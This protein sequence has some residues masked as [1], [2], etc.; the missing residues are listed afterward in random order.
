MIKVIETPNLPKGSVQHII[1]GEKYRNLLEKPLIEHNLA[2]IWLKSNPYVDDRLSGHADL[3]A[4]QI[5]KSM[6]LS[7]YLKYCEQID[8]IAKVEYVPD[9]IKPEYP[10]D[11]GLNFCIVGDKLFYNP[12]TANSELIEK[13]GCTKLMSVKQGY[14]KCSICV[15]DENAIITSDKMIAAATQ[16]IGMDVLYIEKPF[17]ALEG[18]EYGFIGGAAFKISVHE[19]AFTGIIENKI[20]KK[21]IE[22]FLNER[23]IKAIYLTDKPIFDV[24]SAIPLTEQIQ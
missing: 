8:N 4:V 5:G 22:D 16:N 2:P 18:F 6:F 23:H 12:K 3:S 19:L 20:I 7:E 1:I 11:S 24:G 10:H 9:P 14:T 13:S 17:V 15:V 21:E